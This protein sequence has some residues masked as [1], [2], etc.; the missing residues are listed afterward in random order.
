MPNLDLIV[1]SGAGK[2]IGKAIAL[3]LSKTG[4]YILCLSKTENSNYTA[5]EIK[6]HGGNAEGL[7]IDLKDFEAAEEKLI[8]WSNKKNHK[9]IGLVLAAGILGPTGSL[10]STSLKEWE[11]CFKV[12]VFGSLVILKAFLPIMLKNKFGRIITFA[13]GGSAYPFPIFQAYSATKTAMVRISENINED[14]KDK[15]DFAI[16]CLSPGAVETDMLKKVRSAKAEIKTT[17]DISEPVTFAKEFLTAK[18]CGFSG[19]FIH[20]RD[21]WKEYLNSSMSLSNSSLWK[22]RR[23]E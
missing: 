14:L 17:V 16:V 1:V 11:M 13:G 7:T 21:N 18:S 22:L 23:I 15:G 5:E 9:K 8:E 3:E 2:G 12:N 10:I 20:V 19:S 4:S 6:S